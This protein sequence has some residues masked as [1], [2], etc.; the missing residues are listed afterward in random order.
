MRIDKFLAEYGAASRSEAKQL[1]R[2]GQV[3]VNGAV[4]RTPEQKISPKEDE[5][6][7]AGKTLSYEPLEYVMLHKKAGC[8]TALRDDRYPTVMDSLGEGHRS[9]LA[10]VG[11]LDLDTEGLLLL[12]NDGDLAHRMLAPK[13]HVDKVYYARISGCVT[14]EDIHAFAEGLDIGEKRLTLPARLQILASGEESEIELTICEGKFHQVKR[15]FEVR[16]KQVTYL[17]RI[18]MGGISLD[19]TLLPGRWRP[20]TPEEIQCLKCAGGLE[21]GYNTVC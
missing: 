9:D 5:I 11:R 15:M 12:T 10:P 18:S 13:S 1:I 3:T 17:K 21:K 8:V 2:K 20:L 7:C 16:G 4:V 6:C 14:E 19:E